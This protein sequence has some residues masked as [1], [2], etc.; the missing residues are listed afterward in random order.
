[1]AVGNHAG[2]SHRPWAE[3]LRRPRPVRASALGTGPHAHLALPAGGYNADGWKRCCRGAPQ[4][5]PAAPPGS[6]SSPPQRPACHPRGFLFVLPGAASRL[7]FELRC[8][9]QTQHAHPP[10][11]TPGPAPKGP[12]GTLLLGGAPPPRFSTRPLGTAVL[13]R[14]GTC[15]RAADWLAVRAHTPSSAGVPHALR[16][17]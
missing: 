17:F 8:G 9:L 12:W 10:P 4:S 13:K 16:I 2:L 1:M 15:T 5:R 7:S 3:G 14:S 6:L 11:A